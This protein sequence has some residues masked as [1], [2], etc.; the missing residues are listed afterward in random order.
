MFNAWVCDASDAVGDQSAK[1]IGERI[2][3]PPGTLAERL[4]LSSVEHA[5]DETKSGSHSG[6][7]NAEEESCNH[8]SGEVF[9]ST[10]THKDGSPKED[11][12]SEVF[13]GGEFD[14]E[15]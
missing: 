13:P 9:G 2:T 8:Q 14:D 12:D 5:G 3:H 11:G 6:F 4:L 10:M 1:D 7:P 15:V